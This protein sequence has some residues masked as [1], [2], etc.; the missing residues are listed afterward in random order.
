[1]LDRGLAYGD[2]IE[3]MNWRVS[4]LNKVQIYGVGIGRDT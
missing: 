3:T 1:M 2:G 4:K